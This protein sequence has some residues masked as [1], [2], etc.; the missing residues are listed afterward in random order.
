[1][2][3]FLA[4]YQKTVQS[5]KILFNI[6][7]I[8]FTRKSLRPLRYL[9]FI[10]FFIASITNNLMLLFGWFGDIDMKEFASTTM[11]TCVQILTAAKSFCLLASR[12]KFHQCFKWIEKSFLQ[13]FVN[14]RV[15]Y[16][17]DKLRSKN[18]NQTVFVS[19]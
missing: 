7:G 12:T 15:N 10:I 13:T 3:E 11:F 6:V 17:W 5:T 4:A 18:M 9:I 14:S 1:M 8:G 19:R 16:C 2:N